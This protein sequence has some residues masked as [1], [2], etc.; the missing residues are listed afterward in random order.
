[1]EPHIGCWW[2]FTA[3]TCLKKGSRNPLKE[4]Q[5]TGETFLFDTVLGHFVSVSSLE[6]SEIVMVIVI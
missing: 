5:R 3:A 1:M 4:G 6:Y 2:L